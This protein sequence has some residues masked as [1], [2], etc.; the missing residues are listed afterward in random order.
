M[1]V[2]VT[3]RWC[4]RFEPKPGDKLRWTNSAGD[5]GTVVADQWGLVTVEKVRIKTG[6]WTTLRITR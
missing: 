5:E 2:D 1:T 4:Q 6:E 3:P